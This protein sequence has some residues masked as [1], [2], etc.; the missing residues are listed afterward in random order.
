MAE[1]TR[2][3]CWNVHLRPNP[4]R[5]NGTESCIADVRSPS[6]V[7]HNEDIAD[8]IVKERS[9][10][11]KETILHILKLRDQTV[12]RFIQE[13][14]CFTDGI[15]HIRPRVAGLWQNERSPFNPAVHRCKTDM[16]ATAAL[17]NILTKI[18]V[19]VQGIQK[20][21][22]RISTVSDIA[23]SLQDGTLSIGDSIIIA[24]E[25]LKVD[26][27]DLEQ[28]VFFRTEDGTEY[29][30]D[31]RFSLNTPKQLIVRVPAQ[32]PAGQVQL[33]VRTKFTT[34]TRKLKSIREIVCPFACTAV[35]P[36]P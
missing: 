26:Q 30:T 27:N 1:K 31:R 9:E 13:G 36:A 3:F 35:K 17:K 10:F 33:I 11:R 18:T 8:A 7:K 6:A 19:K 14:M 23:T 29:K 22:A 2:T 15:A 5:P 24:G 4:L 12:A 21:S 16:F 32:L 25:K 28:G 34:G 20:M